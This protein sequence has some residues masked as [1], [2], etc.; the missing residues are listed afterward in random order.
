VELEGKTF[1][2]YDDGATKRLLNTTFAGVGVDQ[3][4]QLDFSA[5]S[6]L[7]PT[8]ATHAL[9][10]V[11]TDVDLNELGVQKEAEGG[12]DDDNRSSDGGRRFCSRHLMRLIQPANRGAAPISTAVC[13]SANSHATGFR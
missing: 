3:S 10:K 11:M 9:L 4:A 2:P 8:G 12:A 7:V 6:V 13:R 1:R 5:L